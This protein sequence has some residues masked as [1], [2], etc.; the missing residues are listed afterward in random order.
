M[1]PFLIA[2]CAGTYFALLAFVY[3]AAF[4]NYVSIPQL[5]AFYYFIISFVIF[6][7]LSFIFIRLVERS[8]L[9]AR[10]LSIAILIITLAPLIVENL[11]AD[12]YDPMYILITRIFCESL[13]PTFILQK[14]Y[15]SIANQYL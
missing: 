13:L 12:K 2:L 5:A 8:V 7:I 15:I 6:L 11:F 14:A 10:T 3:D 1:R 4:L 9:N